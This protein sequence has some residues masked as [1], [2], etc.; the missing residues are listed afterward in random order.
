MPD[1]GDLTY[2]LMTAADIGSV[3]LDHQGTPS[4]VRAR[5]ADLGSSAALVF[6]GS[7]HVGQLQFRRYDP[8]LRSPSGLH[9]PLYWGDFSATVAP[10]LPQRALNLFCYHVGQ[11]DAGEA[12]DARYQG[13]GIGSNLLDAL[14]NWADAERFEAIV[15]KAV[16]AVR[17]VAVYMGGQP[18][19]VYEERGF[20]I[21]ARWQDADLLAHLS[22]SM[23]EDSP[24]AAESRRLVKSGEGLAAAGEVAICVRRHP[25]RTSLGLE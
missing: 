17:A 2:R 11:L 16:P 13:R 7:Q 24:L 12:R 22:A 10:E 4:E 15:A 23:N 21:V 20:K 9:D 1:D 6:D 3:P 5:I 25:S 8:D 18:A 19:A 14:I